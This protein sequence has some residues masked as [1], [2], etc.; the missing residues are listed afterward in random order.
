ME[1]DIFVEVLGDINN[2]YRMKIHLEELGLYMY[3]W[4]ARHSEKNESGW[5]I[6]PMAFRVG[7]VWKK[8]PE[9]NKSKTLW[10]QIE[11][12]CI[13][14]IKAYELLTKDVVIVDDVMSEEEIGKGLDDAI[15]KSGIEVE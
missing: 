5:W 3:G 1:Y 15:A 6:Q 12:K 14:A 8:S 2:G 4:T 11:I 7:N 13:E 10:Q 9:F